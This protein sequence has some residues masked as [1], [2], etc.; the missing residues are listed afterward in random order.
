MESFPLKFWLYCTLSSVLHWKCVC[1]F[2]FTPKKLV[3]LFLHWNSGLLYTEYLVFFSISCDLFRWNPDGFALNVWLF[4]WNI[5]EICCYIDFLLFFLNRQIWLF[6]SEPL[7][8]LHLLF[9]TENQIALLR[10]NLHYSSTRTYYP[11]PRFVFCRGLLSMYVRATMTQMVEL[12]RVAVV[13][14]I[15]LQ[16]SFQVAFVSEVFLTVI[17]R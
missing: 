8:A 11:F 14:Y 7:I 13:R 6:Y 2:F 4:T 12:W 3:V 9:C 15:L 5:Q 17:W 1:V 16:L 10:N